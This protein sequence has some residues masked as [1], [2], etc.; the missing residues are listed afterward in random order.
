M[1]QDQ[2]PATFRVTGAVAAI[3]MTTPALGLSASLAKRPPE[4]TGR[5]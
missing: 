4:F 1:D 2:G 5:D 3:T